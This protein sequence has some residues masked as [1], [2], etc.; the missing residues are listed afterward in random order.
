MSAMRARLLMKMMGL[1]VMLVLT[2]MSA[3]SCSGRG[4][5]AS[6]LNPANLVKN[7]VRGLCADQQAVQSA[8]GAPP[9]TA[10]LQAPGGASSLARMAGLGSTAFSCPTTAPGG[11]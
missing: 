6:P 9:G 4:S 1:I 8:S 10:V 11:G 7:G 5:P 3:H 2:V